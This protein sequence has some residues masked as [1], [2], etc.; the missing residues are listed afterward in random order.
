MRYAK[1]NWIRHWLIRTDYRQIDANLFAS[2]STEKYLSFIREALMQCRS[3]LRDDGV[4][5]MVIGDVRRGDVNVRLGEVVARECT[6]STDL[7]LVG[8]VEDRLPI[9]HK[10]SRIWGP[11]KGR[12]TKI[13]R[14]LVLAAP[15]ARIPRQLPKLNW[16][17]C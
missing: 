14:I 1:L 16:A 9:E 10:V 8:M 3:V 11:K 13:E 6:S 7:R 2:G 5:C 4:L 12:A 15:R 17:T